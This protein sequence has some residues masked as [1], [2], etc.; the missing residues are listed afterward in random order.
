[1]SETTRTDLAVIE[2]GKTR[3]VTAMGDERLMI[4][5]KN[6]QDWMQLS[7]FLAQSEMV[8]KIYIGKPANCFVGMQFA[9]RLGLDP[10]TG[11]Q[12]IAIV[13]GKPSLYGDGIP[14][15][16]M[17]CPGFVDLVEIHSKEIPIEKMR[18][19]T[20]RI[21]K[22]DHEYAA[23]CVAI[24]VGRE[25][26]DWRFSIADAKKAGLWGK[27]G[28]WTQYPGRML[29]MRARTFAARDQFADAL[30]GI[31]IFEEISDV[32]AGD[33]RKRIEDKALAQ[34]SQASR[35]IDAAKASVENVESNA[36]L[37]PLSA[38]NPDEVG[39]V[40]EIC[41][42][43]KS[44]ATV[45]ELQDVRVSY[46]AAFANLTDEGQEVVRVAGE[47]ARVRIEGE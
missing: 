19:D 32:T 5:P 38:K 2:G 39:L 14:A 27:P 8:P 22:D 35:I 11:L 10:I 4:Q 17:R 46:G 20:K 3:T 30:S 40:R 12:H 37:R 42:A 45:D 7:E 1:M 31:S 23:R 47:S 29:Q 25:N 16:V 43:L 15:V 44:V 34:S 26:K 18:S 41:D 33:D 13:N 6:M 9:A 24:R 36:D 28:P 21:E